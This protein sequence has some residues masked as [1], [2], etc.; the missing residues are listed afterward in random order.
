MG[1]KDK[2][3]IT[4]NRN[5]VDAN[6]SRN[7]NEADFAHTREAILFVLRILWQAASYSATK[8][9]PIVNELTAQSVCW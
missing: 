2:F 1:K 6:C 9:W 8:D 3:E 4:A 7:P 5:E